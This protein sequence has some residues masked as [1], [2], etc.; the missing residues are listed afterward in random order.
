[1]TKEAVTKLLSLKTRNE[2]PMLSKRYFSRS[3]RCS[4]AK[5]WRRTCT[6]STASSCIFTA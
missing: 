4:G 1:M 5:K 6:V 2:G 3:Y